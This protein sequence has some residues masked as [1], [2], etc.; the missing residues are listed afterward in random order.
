MEDVIFVDASKEGNVSRFINVSRRQFVVVLIGMINQ[1]ADPRFFLSLALCSTAANQTCSSRTSSPTPTTPPSP[2]SPSSP[3]GE[4]EE[5]DKVTKR[6]VFVFNPRFLSISVV[7]AGTELTWNYSA[8][9]QRKQEVPCLCGSEDCR[10]E[11]SMENLCDM[12]EAEGEK[13]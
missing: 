3:T 5:G 10:G 6:F 1:N 7:K 9:V 8:D 4:E 12:C 2:S 13:P 11:L